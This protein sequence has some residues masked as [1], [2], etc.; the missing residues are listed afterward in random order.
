[1]IALEAMMG[2][3]VDEALSGGDFHGLAANHLS[4][5]ESLETGEETVGDGRGGAGAV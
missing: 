5:R 4:I 3:R 2:L 1:M